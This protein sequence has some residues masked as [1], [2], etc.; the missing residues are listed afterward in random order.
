MNK[1][2]NILLFIFNFN[3]IVD[4]IQR[5]EYQNLQMILL[6]CG[7]KI[8]TNVYKTAIQSLERIKKSESET[9]SL[10]TLENLVESTILPGLSIWSTYL[11]SNLEV[12]SQYCY[13]ADGRNSSPLPTTAK[14]REITKKSLIKVINR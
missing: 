13:G 9:S 1:T 14:P 2:F 12:I 5:S 7:F 4:I 6:E 3:F 10:S 11:Y 8:I